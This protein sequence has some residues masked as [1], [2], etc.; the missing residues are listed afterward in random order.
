MLWNGAYLDKL[1]FAGVRRGH[2]FLRNQ[3]LTPATLDTTSSRWLRSELNPLVTN[4]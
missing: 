1:G 4:C 3:L 2:L